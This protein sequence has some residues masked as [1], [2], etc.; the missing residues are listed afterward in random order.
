MATDEEIRR[1]IRE[2]FADGEAF[3]VS[4]VASALGASVDDIAPT[5]HAMAEEGEI[6]RVFEEGS[7]TLV[8]RYR[9]PS[10]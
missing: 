8:Y 2:Q 10:A 3:K 6:E 5:L 4:A 1:V 9:R 7:S